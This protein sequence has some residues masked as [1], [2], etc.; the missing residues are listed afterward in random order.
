MASLLSDWTGQTLIFKRSDIVTL[1]FVLIIFDLFC[2]KG[3]HFHAVTQFVEHYHETEEVR[4]LS[5]SPVQIPTSTRRKSSGRRL[6]VTCFRLFLVFPLK[7]ANSSKPGRAVSVSACWTVYSF[8]VSW[9]N[10]KEAVGIW[11]RM[12]AQC[13]TM[14]RE[15]NEV[16]VEIKHG[17]VELIHRL[18]V[19]WK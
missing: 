11:G 5:P 7:A 13:L 16:L 2:L 10:V 15:I 6:S 12:L 4:E 9:G 8:Y 17:A 14:N 1:C 3:A 19:L 18:L